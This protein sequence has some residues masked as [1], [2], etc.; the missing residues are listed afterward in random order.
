M[1]Y[2]IQIL[3]VGVALVLS[4]CSSGNSAS[5]SSSWSWQS[6]SNES[7]AY[8][9]YG[10][11]GVAA[12]SNIPGARLGSISWADEKGNF[13]LFGGAGNAA[14]ES[15]SLNDLW[16]YNPTTKQWTWVGGSN[17]IDAT[18]EYGTQEVASTT[19]IPGARYGGVSWRDANNNLWT[20]GGQGKGQGDTV[21][22]FLNDLWEY[23][24]TSNEWTWQNGSKTIVSPG[25]YGT[26]GVGGRL[27]TPS[28]RIGS[29]TWT[30]S[31]GQLWLFGGTTIPGV[32]VYN[33][34]WRY[35]PNLNQ[36]T[37]VGGEST[38]NEAGIYGTKVIDAVNNQP[39][40]RYD[41]I[42]WIDNNGNLWLFGG[43]GFDSSGTFGL[44][45]DL[46]K[47]NPTTKIWTWVN[48]SKVVN[49]SGVYG[50][51]GSGA[52]NNT[53]GAREHRNPF[54]WS[55]KNGNLWM[56]G[57]FGRANSTVGLLNDLWTYNPSN[58][59]WTWAAGSNES[60]ATGKYGLLG[61]SANSNMPGA[62]RDAIGWIDNNS[63]LWVFG[64]SG[65]GATTNGKLNDLW[66][67]NGI[68]AN[69]PF[70][71]IQYTLFPNYQSSPST[72]ITGVRGITNSSNVYLS[73]IWPSPSTSQGLVYAGPL[74]G[75]GGQWYQLNYASSPGSTVKA[76]T[77]Y[78]PNNGNATGNIS[79]VGSYTTVES[80]TASFGLLYQGPL[81]GGNNPANWIVITP[82]NATSTIAHSNM[83][84]L[85]VGN[86]QVLG[87][88]AGKG[89][90][91]NIKTGTYFT[92]TKQGAVSLTIYGIWQNSGNSYTVAGGYSNTNES[93]MDI[94]YIADFDSSNNAV[95]NFTSYSYDNQSL[96]SF[97]SHFEG[98]TGNGSIG[99]NL[100]GDVITVG[101]LTKVQPNFVQ[102]E[103][104]GSTLSPVAKWT[105]VFYPGA[106][107]ISGNTVFENNF[108]GVFSYSDTTQVSA[109]IASVPLSQ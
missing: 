100:V 87:D 41:A 25:Y 80:G 33:D 60:D 12:S 15:G 3:S 58:N 56:F 79:V 83:G 93:G 70:P 40:A 19:N 51:L 61:V 62:R 96:G 68:N 30:D 18:S 43:S 67:Y 28:G 31:S 4:A 16:K 108:L 105:E 95:T 7:D 71:M 6:G 47:Y 78:G 65:N 17:S 27:N 76:T 13:W 23:N 107:F 99:Y 21:V 32:V 48:G 11:L 74:N 44:L 8:G 50:T 54:A 46:W 59:Y 63:N 91:Y 88:P 39:G 52:S 9:S 92:L 1:R 36:W 94:G 109:F 45:N 26:Q 14:T 98:I 5:S 29:V 86:Y 102:V 49:Q 55:D 103:R 97:I 84:D 77:L 69:S 22:G 72:Y 24:P 81:T 38:T 53:P 75:V 64:G 73:V 37:W 101:D 89:F 42:S 35:N 10:S 82:P 85:A 57:G 104:I 106:K 90:I 66:K 20:F 34:L 2:F